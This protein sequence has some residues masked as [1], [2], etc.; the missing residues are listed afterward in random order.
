[1]HQLAFLWFL[2]LTFGALNSA[3]S[4]GN[5]TFMDN[6]VTIIVIG[7]SNKKKLLVPHVHGFAALAA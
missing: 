5:I 3:L 7:T 1:M 6:F 2:L 4:E